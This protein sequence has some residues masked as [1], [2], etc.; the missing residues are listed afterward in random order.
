[1]FAATCLRRAF[2]CLFLGV[3]LALHDCRTDLVDCVLAQVDSLVS[4]VSISLFICAR[5]GLIL[6]PIA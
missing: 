5:V 6:F 2:I 1:M 3:V 4:R